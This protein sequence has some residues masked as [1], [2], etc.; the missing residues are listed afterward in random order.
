MCLLDPRSKNAIMSTF[1][2]ISTVW[3]VVA[4]A[5]LVVA[6]NM[7]RIGRTVVHRNIMVLL[8]L[9]AW[10]FILS[11]IFGQRYGDNFESFPRE[12]VP[13]MALHGSLGLVPLLGATCLVIA[14]LMADRNKF[15]THFNRHHR[16]YG[17]V[18]IVVWCF[19]HLG[20]IFNA[21]FL[22]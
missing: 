19:T 15:S 7:A 18:F 8:T 12:Y 16:R 14:R 17:R 9:G 22:R 21:F 10:V 6:W 2:I 4:L 20:G 3:A 11:Y 5:L 13:W 1:L